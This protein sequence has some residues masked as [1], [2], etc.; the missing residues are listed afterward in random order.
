M[1]DN[2]RFLDRPPTGS[3]GYSVP[4][5]FVAKSARAAV[6][7][8]NILAFHEG[9]LFT[10]RLMVRRG[11]LDTSSW[12]EF[13]E[14]AHE[15]DARST[16]AGGT[17]RFRVHFDDGSHT[18][19]AQRPWHG[20]TDLPKLP[21]LAEVNG[22]FASDDQ[23]LHGH[24]TVWLCPLPPSALF[25]FE[26]EWQEMGLETASTVLDGSAIAHAADHATQLWD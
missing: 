18:E 22:E 25:R 21:L 13:C 10:L 26:I 15:G 8:Q 4:V 7:L 17:L 19:T 20:T 12:N 9:C 24:L 16:P 23:A 11:S 5:Q 14:T 2:R 6:A 1:P 3:L